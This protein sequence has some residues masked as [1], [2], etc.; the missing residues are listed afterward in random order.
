MGRGAV[1]C[2]VWPWGWLL[3]LR[4]CKEKEAGRDCWNLGSLSG[5]NLVC[6]TVSY[7]SPEGY[8]WPWTV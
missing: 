1:V 3:E 5:K 7:L 6:A 2:S 8:L 4:D